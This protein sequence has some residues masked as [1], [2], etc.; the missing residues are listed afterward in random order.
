MNYYRESPQYYQF[1][2]DITGVKN[3]TYF[4]VLPYFRKFENNLDKHLVRDSP[5]VHTTGGPLTITTANPD[6]ILRAYLKAAE[7]VGYPYTYPDGR[8]P[9]G[10]TIFQRNIKRGVR[11]STSLVFLEHN[12]RTNL[13][14]LGQTLVTKIVFNERKR[15]IGVQFYR[16]YKFHTVFVRNEVIVSAGTIGSPKLLMLSGVGPKEHLQSLGIPVV[17]DRRVGDNF[18]QGLDTVI[19]FDIK[20]QSLIDKP[21]E[22]IENY[23]KY[24]I[25]GTGPLAYIAT[26]ETNFP[27]ITYLGIPGLNNGFVLLR[28]SQLGSDLEALVKNFKLKSE[29]REYYRPYLN[30]SRLTVV[31]ALKKPLSVGTIRLASKNPF[32]YP[33]LDPCLMCSERDLSDLVQTF[34]L[35]LDIFLSPFMRQF[36]EIYKNPIPGCNPCPNDYFCESYIRCYLQTFTSETYP[37]GGCRMGVVTDPDAVVDN[38]LRVF[39]VSGL[40]VIDSSV[41]PVST[42]QSTM[43]TVMIAEYASDLIKHDYLDQW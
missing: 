42:D 12:Y 10:S 33:V 29:W 22:T 26:G 14:I 15:A 40:R 43:I 2:T 41:I 7:L 20:N 5:Y 6:P 18:L 28:V 16:N 30:R 13:H 21:S 17:A 25:N 11:Q 35:S 37:M 24:F 8:Q 27:E 34:R 9:F 4:D 32:Q 39:G 1:W 31:P 19:N 38:K 23:A 36:I 3:W